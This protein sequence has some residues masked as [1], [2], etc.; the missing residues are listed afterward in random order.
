MTTNAYCHR[1]VAYARNHLRSVV[2][3]YKINYQNLCSPSTAV[4]H[5]A[6]CQGVC[7]APQIPR[8]QPQRSGLIRAK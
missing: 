4:S 6:G 3:V 8:E 5:S 2:R 7:A 1:C